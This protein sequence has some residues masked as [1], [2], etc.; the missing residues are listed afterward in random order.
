L[1]PMEANPRLAMAQWPRGVAALAAGRHDE[2]YQ[3]LRR[4]FDPAESAYHPHMRAWVLVDLVEAAVHSGHENEASRFVRELRSIAAQSRS[5]L[6]ESALLFTRAVLSTVE[7]EAAYQG[8]AELVAWP[9]TRARLQLA[10]G[11]WL[12]RQRRAADA[13]VPLRA[14]RD[15]FDVL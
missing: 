15:M 13:R 11:I 8:G 12:R 6:L 10:Y 14:A 2:A 5:P 1:R 3:H 9:F 7:D 4:I